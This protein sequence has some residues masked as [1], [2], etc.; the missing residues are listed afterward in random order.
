MY[1]QSRAEAGVKLA[2]RLLKYRDEPCV[3][4]ALS[5]G[6]VL[7]GSRIAAAL[8]C[9]LCLLMVESIDVPGEPDP[10]GNMNQEG[11]ISYNTELTEEEL[12]NYQSEY[13]QYIEQEKIDKFYKLAM[14]SDA[15]GLVRRDLLRGHCVIMVSDGLQ[16][17]YQLDAASFYLKPIKAKKIVIATPLADITAVDRMHL[18]GD[19]ILCLDVVQNFMDTNHYY[20]DNTMPEHSMILKTVRNIVAAASKT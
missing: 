1:Y 19:D 18:L 3:V 14:N 9:P 2:E 11:G 17:T 15:D 10:Y 12:E 16:G 8:N 5:D 6:G 13:H 20:D 4:L 7:V